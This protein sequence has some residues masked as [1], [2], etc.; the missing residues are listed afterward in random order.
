M[1]SVGWMETSTDNSG[2]T[3]QG[4][5]RFVPGLAALSDYDRTWLRYELV[6]GVSVAAV[7]VPVAMAYSH[8]AG[9]PPV[10]GLYASLLPLVAYALLG[11]SR[12]LIVAPD[13]ATC[14]IVAAVVAPMA[15]G[16]PA[17]YLSLTAALAVITGVFCIAAGLLRLGFLSNFLARPILTGYLNGIAIWII[18]SQLGT[19]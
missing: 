15:G 10:H 17:R 6:A 5:G 2:K 3:K 1:V 13:G 8:L 14:A 11:S 7:A 19:L 4:I 9:V 18:T 12:Q 16:D